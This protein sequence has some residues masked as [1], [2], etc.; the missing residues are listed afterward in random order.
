MR[1]RSSPVAP[2][3][4]TCDEPRAAG[5][6]GLT[7]PEPVRAR[8]KTSFGLCVLRNSGVS[9]KANYQVKVKALLW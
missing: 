1:L 2:A 5:L 6:G 3:A 8:N 7:M 4:Y 9:S